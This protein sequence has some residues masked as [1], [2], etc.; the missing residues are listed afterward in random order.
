MNNLII[1]KN[2]YLNFPLYNTKKSIRSRLLN[3]NQNKIN[4]IEA[5]KNIS[6]E[7]NKGDR[8]GLLGKNGSGKTTLL[9]VLAGIYFP[10]SGDLEV[11]EKPFP[12][13]DSNMGLNPEATGVENIKMISYLSGFNSL[14]SQS[15]IDEI[16][17]FS[18]LGKFMYLPV[19]T[20]SSGMKVRLTTSIGIQINPKL[21][22]IDE[23]FAAGDKEFIEKA[24]KELIKKFSRLEGLVFASHNE[25]LI[26][27]VCNRIFT[28]ENGEIIK[29]TIV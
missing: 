7:L 25:S 27:S 10:S 5:L 6:F 28:L 29:D 4:F 12:I 13:L 17:D 15:V 2:L 11:A 8:I 9:K 21:L 16:E 26:N 20:Y 24:K 22:L 1:A 23:F 14:S 3:K 18:E 19:R